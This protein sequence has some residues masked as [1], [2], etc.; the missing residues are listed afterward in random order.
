[1]GFDYD[2][3]DII[4]MEYIGDLMIGKRKDKL[5]RKERDEDN[6]EFNKKDIEE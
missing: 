3:R 5:Y 4:I 1:M 2:T 6:E